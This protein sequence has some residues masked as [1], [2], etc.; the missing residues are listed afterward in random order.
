MVGVSHTGLLGGLFL[1]VDRGVVHRWFGVELV[2]VC[3]A[4][5]IPL[6]DHRPGDG[7]APL[8]LDDEVGFCRANAAPICCVSP[9]YRCGYVVLHFGD[10]S[11][12]FNVQVR[13]EG[14]VEVRVPRAVIVFALSQAG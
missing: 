2:C 4:V 7:A 5:L 12:V 1:R 10:A 14:A 13:C 3:S 6:M 9:D 11:R 8:M